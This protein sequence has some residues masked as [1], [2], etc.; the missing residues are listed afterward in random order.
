MRS[1]LLPFIFFILTISVNAQV[2][3]D[4]YFVKFTDKNNSPYSIDNP[5]EYLS[6]RAIERR[7]NQG[8]AIDLYDLPVNP[9][10]LA[11]VAATGATLDR[12][13]VV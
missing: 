3:P 1:V 12:K 7:L 10:Y 9:D 5:S 11:G 4:K 13:S 8:I 6:Q 2:A